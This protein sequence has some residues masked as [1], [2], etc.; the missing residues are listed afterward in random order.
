MKDKDS[1]PSIKKLF[2]EQSQRFMMKYSVLVVFF[3]LQMVVSHLLNH[4]DYVVCSYGP[5]HGGKRWLI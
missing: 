4:P 2:A 3:I 5:E 1:P